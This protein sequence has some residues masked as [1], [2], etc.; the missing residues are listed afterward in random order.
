M[1]KPFNFVHSQAKH[2]AH[3]KH[4]QTQT[5][6]KMRIRVMASSDSMMQ[7]QQGLCHSWNY[8]D[9]QI[10]YINHIGCSIFYC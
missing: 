1:K 3:I 8:P 5:H 4:R 10:K 2:T 6:D 9:N 7:W